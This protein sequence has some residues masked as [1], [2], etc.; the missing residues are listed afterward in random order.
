MHEPDGFDPKRAARK[1]IS[2]ARI[3]SLATLDSGG[4]P[5]VSLVT[6]ATMPDGSPVLLL[7]SLA[8]HTRNLRGDPRVSLLVS[9]NGEGDPLEGARVSISGRIAVTEEPAAKRRFLLRNPSAEN[10]ASFKDFSFYRIEPSGAHLVA[11]FGKI[12]D[13]KAQDLLIDTAN[14][15]SLLEAE[16][17]AVE[18]M[19]EDHLDA[20][21]LYATKL[22]GAEPG[23][24]RV[25]GADPEGCDLM[26]RGIVRR[27]NFPQRV[28]NAGDLR[29]MLVSLA[30]QA[31]AS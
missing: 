22:L 8:R 21:E 3:G 18:H 11:G 31:R 14:A 23:P 5:Y 29:K 20:I 30:Q 27:L 26:L 17:G 16:A 15:A 19:N 1:L 28:M 2:E 10:Y 25:I 9:E 4:S 24:W 7:S 12:A 13:V 6:V